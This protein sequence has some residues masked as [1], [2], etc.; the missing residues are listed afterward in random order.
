MASSNWASSTRVNSD[1]SEGNAEK[2]LFRLA[3]GRL[4]LLSFGLDEWPSN[5]TLKIAR[6]VSMIAGIISG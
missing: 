6:F 5:H 4:Q 2:G 3:E 1:V